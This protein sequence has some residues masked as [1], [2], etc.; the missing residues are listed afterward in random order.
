MKILLALLLLSASTLTTACA[1]LLDEPQAHEDDAPTTRAH[2]L[3]QGDMPQPDPFDARRVK[4]RADQLGA[5]ELRVAHSVRPAHLPAAL[6]Q[7]P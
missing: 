5:L 2:A 3:H 6:D 1:G 4:A 7:R